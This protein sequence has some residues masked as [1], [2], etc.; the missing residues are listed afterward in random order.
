MSKETW[1]E[2]Q[3]SWVPLKTA[4]FKFGIFDDASASSEEQLSATTSEM[5][6]SGNRSLAELTNLVKEKCGASSVVID[7]MTATFTILFPEGDA[8]KF[9]GPP[10]YLLALALPGY[11]RSDRGGLVQIDAAR[12]RSGD[13]DRNNCAVCALSHCLTTFSATAC[14]RLASAYSGRLEPGGSEGYRQHVLL[15]HPRGPHVDERP[16]TGSKREL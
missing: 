1:T 8:R 6:T 11:R 9:T 13:C 14:I 10:W 16:I 3:A 2:P 15:D 4:V 12:F 5:R 7:P